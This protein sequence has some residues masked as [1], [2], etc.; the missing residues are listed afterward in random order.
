MI[1]ASINSNHTARMQYQM[2]DYRHITRDMKNQKSFL[3]GQ[4]KLERELNYLVTKL[5]DLSPPYFSSRYYGHMCWENTIPS[6][7]GY[8][9]GMLYNPNNTAY[10][11]SPFTT[12]LE[13]EVLKLFAEVFKLS[14]MLGSDTKPDN[15]RYKNSWGHL[16]CG[17]TVANCEGLWAARNCRFLALSLRKYIQEL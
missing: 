3:D 17:G 7:V 2:E 15:T 5:R 10:E 1:T 16:T 11:A 8:F 6:L 12:L 9:A 4:D 14:P 13:I